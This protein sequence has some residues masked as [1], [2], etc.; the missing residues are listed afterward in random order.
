MSI[1][2]C[3]TTF[4]AM[5]G[6][7]RVTLGDPFGEVYSVFS[8]ECCSRVQFTAIYS[9]KWQ[10]TGILLPLFDWKANPQT[11][12]YLAIYKRALSVCLCVSFWIFG[13]L[14][15]SPPVFPSYSCTER[16][17]KILCYYELFIHCPI[18]KQK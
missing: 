15:L 12:Y 17:S 5:T 7:F 6:K 3:F 9:P 11:M 2:N 4:M 18:F 10:L 14:P 16:D 8:F 1:T 13:E